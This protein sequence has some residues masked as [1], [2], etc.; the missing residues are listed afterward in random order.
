MPYIDEIRRDGVNPH[1][2]DLVYEILASR[3]LSEKKEGV[4]NYCITRLIREVMPHETYADLNAI[5]GILECCKQE[6]YR[7]ICA[8][9]EDTKRRETGDVY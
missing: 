7:R 9:Y 8:P 4:L 2:R 5:I 3:A 1:V 6:Y